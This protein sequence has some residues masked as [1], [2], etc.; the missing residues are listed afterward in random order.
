[1]KKNQILYV[2]KAFFFIVFFVSQ[3]SFGQATFNSAATGNWNDA[4]KWTVMSG[5]DADNI[6][7]ADD[8]VFIVSNHS[9][10]VNTGLQV[11]LSLTVGPL[12]GGNSTSTLAFASG[13]TLTVGGNVALGNAGNN[14]RKGSIVMTNGGTLVCQGFVLNNGGTNNFTE[15]IGTVVLTANNTLP[16]TIFTAFNNLTINAGSTTTASLIGI[17]GNLAVNSG[18]ALTTGNTNSWILGVTGTTSISGTLNLANTGAKTFSNDVTIGSNGIWNETSAAGV[19]FTGSLQNDGTF[20]SGSGTHTFSGTSKTING[21]SGVSIPNL[22]ISGTVTNSTTITSTNLAG[23][24]TLTNAAS[25]ILNYA[26]TTIAPTLVATAAGNVVNYNGTTQTVKNTSYSNLALSTSGTKSFSAA[27]AISGMLSVSGTAKATFA[28]NTNSTAATLHLGGSIQSAGTWG[29]TGSGAGNINTTYFNATTNGRITI[30]GT[31]C[32]LSGLWLGGTS[33]DWNSA[34]NWWCGVPSASTDVVIPQGT[35]FQPTIATAT[36]ALC[37]N[38]TIKNGATLTMANSATSF[39]NISGDFINNG[40]L[41]AGVASTI[42]FVGSSAQVLG[43]NVS[44]GFA[45]LVINTATSAV[46]V[47]NGTSAFTTSGDL[48]VTSGDLIL[49]ATDANYTI[50]G[51]VTVSANG[52]LTHNV[53]WD[54]AG[55][56]LSVGGHIAIDGVYSKGAAGRAHVQMSGSA[57]NVHTGTSSLSILTLN[58]TG[59]IT[60]DGPLTVDNN[61][62]AMI[63]LAGGSFS[64]NGQTVVANSALLNSGGTLNINGGSLT[65]S[66][67]LNCGYNPGLAGNIVLSSGTLTTDVLTI[68]ASGAINGTLSQTGGTLNVNGNITI[69]STTPASS[70]VCSNSPV[71]NISGNWINNGTYTKA[72]ETVTFNGTTAISG[73]STNSFHNLVISNIL[74]AP[75]S[76]MNVSGTWTNNGAFTPNGGT[77]VLN[78]AAQQLLNGSATTG[79]YN[80]SV[81]NT[82]GALLATDQQVNNILSLTGGNLNLGTK[83]LSMGAAALAISGSFSAARMIVADGGGEIRKNAT[84]NATASYTFPIG[85]N[86]GAAEYTPITLAVTGSGYSSAY[87]GVSVN[88]GK[89]INN[90]STT[91]FLTRYWNVRQSGITGC[92]VNVTGTFNNTAADVSGTLGNIRTA[93][94]NGIF[95][96]ATNPWIKTGGIVLSN[97]SFTYTGATLTAGQTSVFT[98]ITGANP[99]VNITGGGVTICQNGTA[100]LTVVP[101]GDS[102][103]TY[104][105]AG[106]ITG[107]TTAVTA[108]PDTSVLGTNAYTV[109]IKDGNGITSAVS[110]SVNVN[111]VA[112]PAAGALTPTPAQGAVCIGTS[113]SATAVA[114]TG[115]SG[116]MADELEYSLSGG[117]YIPYVSGTA[118]STSG[119]TSVSIRTRRTATGTG[120]T[121]S[122]YNTITWSVTPVSAAGTILGGGTFCSGSDAALSLSGHAGAIQWQSSTDNISFS[123]ISGATSTAYNAI[124]VTG[125]TY[126][127]VVVTNGPC[128]S[129]TS[130]SISVGLGG[131]T[132]WNGSWS[133]GVPSS[134]MIAT[135]SANYTAT[136]NFAAC[137]LTVDNNAVVTIPSGFDLTLNGALTIS[138]GSVTLENNANLLQVTNAANSGNIIVKR[139]SS[140][141][142]RQD[143][144]LWSSPVAN[145]NLLAFSPL[146][147][148]T[149]TS[150]F[151]QYNSAANAYNSIAS[152]STANFNDAQGYLIRVANNH[153]AFA[154]VWNGKFTGVPHNGNYSY[155]M[156]NGGAGLRY[157]VVGNPYPSPI[158]AM[159]FAAANSANI[160]RTLYFWRETN[161]NTSNN[162]YCSWSPAGG[163]TGTFVT[164]GQAQV[165]DINGVIQTGQGFFVEAIDAATQVNFTNAMRVA[166]H[167]NQFYRTSV[168]ALPSEMESHRIWLNATNA[169]GA[170]CQTAIGYMTDATNAPDPGID[171][172]YV[173]TGALE[174]YTTIDTDRY[175]IQGRAL[176]FDA[177]DIVPLG[178]NSAAAGNYTIAIDHVDGLFTGSQDVYLRDNLTG[179]IHDLKDGAYNF[180]TEAGTFTARF[181]ILYQ[182]ALGTIHPALD[183]AAVVVYKHAGGF[184]I[185]S[186]K[187][188]MDGIK[189]FDIRGRLLTEKKDINANEAAFN[190]GEANQVLIVKVMTDDQRE[191]TVKVVN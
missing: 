132:T 175:V 135:I 55:R 154:W 16:G 155:T 49:Q 5:L 177:A 77:V 110:G 165:G 183:A 67:G 123:N 74:T 108:A 50:S 8:T 166:N 181:E 163:P 118:I 39:L 94:L 45:N 136:S 52:T 41:S 178:F 169:E 37:R 26:G 99:T 10:T 114:G 184:M 4:T 91:H 70:L 133:N 64:T 17:A 171:G 79:F 191:V 15:G 167:A 12:S 98:G 27:T 141:I 85:D 131:S 100:T 113:V 59:A 151:Y 9:I 189:V 130:S 51:N 40:T 142:K 78:G 11:C 173:N 57:K 36:T 31:S 174:L 28:N 88:D 120:C 97:A 161:S 182:N 115:G 47:T 93:Q 35:A 106:A 38:I 86:T 61:F 20:L 147:V 138:S 23:G 82:N 134:T 122:G 56:Q 80:L 109:T 128:S 2:I 162:A 44:T 144:T 124:N 14:N 103:F 3:A 185:N 75:S 95:N 63:G 186:G 125:T 84:S 43:G 30:S 1:M 76:T 6:P 145:Q 105:W 152:P 92:S 102:F 24:G 146:T 126:Y 160:T 48:T 139:N 81:S 180:A 72:T 187:L 157:N 172:K 25:G 149:P 68:G 54:S 13:T 53:D 19:T 66:G 65:V 143:Y 73:T 89:H 188:T 60:A 170:F 42:T 176:P 140:A 164:N 116:T 158:N 104:S 111:V 58:T 168:V 129:A 127:R 119:Q 46:A 137:R 179:V 190:A 62:W 71:I 101:L 153:P 22:A 34:A 159:A 148:V 156:Y 18:A 29:G 150:R 21:T 69:V 90:A 33:T 117:N 121:A 87:V 107:S 32:S 96:Q 83:T 7:D 112:L